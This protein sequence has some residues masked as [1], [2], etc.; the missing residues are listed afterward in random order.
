MRLL[1]GWYVR[2]FNNRYRRT[3]PL[4]DGRFRSRTVTTGIYFLACSRYIERNPVRAGLVDECAAYPWSSFHHNGRGQADP[5]LTPHPIYATLGGDR[6]SRCAV[7]R[8]LFRD[9]VNSS[10]AA[11]IRTA[12]LERGRLAVTSYQD[13]VVARFSAV[14][15]HRQ[16]AVDTQALVAD[17]TAGE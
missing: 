3:G 17:D 16:P 13:A 6:I 11:E 1:G 8:E 9:E 15:Q 12:P 4:W 14:S 10:V 2:Y 7:Y 5:V